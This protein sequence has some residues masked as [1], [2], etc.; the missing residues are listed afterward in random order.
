VDGRAS[1]RI[2]GDKEHP[3]SD[4]LLCQKG[5]G[6]TWLGQPRD[7]R[8]TPLCRPDDGGHEPIDWTRVSEIA[9]KLTRG[10]TRDTEGRRRARSAT[11]AG[12]PGATTPAVA[13]GPR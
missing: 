1:T 4:V 11:W 2:R 3:R 5:A 10:G 8:T 12:W 13:T 7:R 6:L 9:R